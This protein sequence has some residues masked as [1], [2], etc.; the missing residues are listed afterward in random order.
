MDYK[1]EGDKQLKNGNYKDYYF[2]YKKYYNITQ[3]DESL[4]DVNNAKKK[5]ELY[6]EMCEFL[7]KDE[8]NYYDILGLKKEATQNDIRES[9]TKLMSR[10]H[11][12]KTKIKES[13]SVSRIIQK[14][15]IILSNKKKRKEYD[16]S[17]VGCFLGQTPHFRVII[18]NDLNRDTFFSDVINENNFRYRRFINEEEGIWG[19]FNDDY[20][21]FNNMMY[22]S[23][24]RFSPPRRFQRVR[25]DDQILVK[26]IALIIIIY[27]Y[28]FLH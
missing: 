21:L 7:K 22:R 12:D 24:F 1:T 8:K 9:Y 28:I 17:L 5:F 15:Y 11:P 25:W 4:K 20:N 13:N 6:N 18:E 2:N 16:D 19:I 10:Y 23:F 27:F 26:I 3:T 14:A